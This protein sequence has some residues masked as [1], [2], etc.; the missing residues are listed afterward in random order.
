[1]SINGREIGGILLDVRAISVE[2]LRWTMV[3]T[4]AEGRSRGPLSRGR[5]EKGPGVE[6][7]TMKGGRNT[8][9]LR[10]MLTMT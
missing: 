1:M 2:G 5:M 7:T 3:N 4:R 9:I 10:S 8:N 6:E